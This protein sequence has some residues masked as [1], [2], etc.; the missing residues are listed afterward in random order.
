MKIPREENW[1]PNK[2]PT[3]DNSALVFYQNYLC[4]QNS[5]DI[6]KFLVGI[7]YQEDKTKKW[8]A[9]KLSIF[10]SLLGTFT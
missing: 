8:I 3:C 4:D 6:L 9:T 2:I 7:K 5:T 10:Q 1:V